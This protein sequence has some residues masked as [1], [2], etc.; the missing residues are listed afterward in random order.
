M[1][2]PTRYDLNNGL[3]LCAKCHELGLISASHAPWIVYEWLENNRP[4]QYAWFLQARKGIVSPPSMKLTIQDYR[5]IL[6]S[7]LNIFEQLFPQ[8]IKSCKY[9]PFTDEEEIMI[10]SDYTDKI[11]SR[12]DLALKYGVTEIVITGVLRR[13]KIKMRKSGSNRQEIRLLKKEFMS[14]EARDV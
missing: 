7:L 11:L 8:T 10:C 1:Y 14:E 5:L 12:R 4:E 13:R 2:A 3:S 6:K 9:N